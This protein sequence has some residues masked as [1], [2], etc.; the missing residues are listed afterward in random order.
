MLT[1]KMTHEELEQVRNSDVN[2]LRLMVNQRTGYEPIDP[3]V[4]DIISRSV[5][6]EWRVQMHDHIVID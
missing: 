6:R 1:S 5:A 2:I 3:H 4:H